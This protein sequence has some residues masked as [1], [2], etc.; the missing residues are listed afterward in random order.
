[1]KK[2]ACYIRSSS[3]KEDQNR[4]LE[5]QELLLK[6]H[7]KDRDIIFYSD[8]CTGTSF[9]RAGFQKL[10]Y[11]AG[12]NLKKLNDGRITFEADQWRE[13]LFEE[14][15][16]INASRFSRS[17]SI[18]EVLRVLWDYKKINVYFVDIMKNSNNPN[19][20]PL[21]NMFFAMAEN[22]VIETSK[23]TKRGNSISIMQNRIRNVS[24]FGFDFDRNNNKL[25]LNE[26]E[27]KIVKFI[28]KTSLTNGLKNTAKIVNELGY[29][30]K[31]GNLW[32]DST[33]KTL[34]TNPKYK[35]YNV[36]NKFNS[37]NLFTDS[38][39]KY[40]RKENWVI[41][42]SE[43]IEAI[44]SEELWQ[45]VQNAL[46]NRC[47]NGNRGINSN[48]YDTKGKL[49][50]K[51]CGSSYNRAVE[52]AIK[53]KPIGQHYLICMKKKKFTKDVCNS[54]NIN[55]ETLNNYIE[56]QCLNYYKRIK[57]MI[58]IKIIK[59]KNDIEKIS[60]IDREY[61]NKRVINYR[62]FISEINN[63]IDENIEKELNEK[64]LL[65][66]SEKNQKNEIKAKELKI[67]IEELEL[68]I[69]N[70]K[71]YIRDINKRIKILEKERLELKEEKIERKEWLERVEYI[72]VGGKK[73][74]KTIYKV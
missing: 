33:I 73:D 13:P 68:I 54:E 28:Y 21:L 55:I 52:K 69:S 66:L 19:D 27:A 31:K 67:E 74:L 58:D 23:R 11:D 3:N 25:I 42:K 57:F 44:I 43:D 49:I 1:M 35:G 37:V 24:I 2:I 38:K 46:K 32:S 64:E 45:E 22:E 4:A 16:V 9:K 14:I 47:L 51:I 15:A 65:K 71:D 48:K 41:Q 36:R 56:L 62:K 70:K 60:K 8:V 63:L 39:V 20:L 59:L 40:V 30:T 72:I 61:I 53:N 7:Y 5:Q 10:M 18:I 50:C 29:R 26:E 17:V 12:L 34:I 6:N